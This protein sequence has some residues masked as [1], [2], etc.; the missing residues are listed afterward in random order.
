[1]NAILSSAYWPNL[2]YFYYLIN[3]EQVQIE[4]HEH[5]QKQ[6][7][8]NRTQILSANGVLNLVIPVIQKHKKMPM[9]AVEIDYNENWQMNHWR[10]I[11]SAYKN[12]P[13]FDFFEDELFVFYTQKEKML[14]DYNL[15][16]LELIFKILRKKRNFSLTET[17]ETSFDNMR[18]K[19]FDIH[20]KINF[21][22]D[23]QAYANLVK[24]YYQ[25]FSEKFNFVPN[26]SVL[27]LIFNEGKFASSYL[28][29]E[30]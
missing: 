7:F 28:N 30:M 19:R 27:D 17:F 14:L 10:A 23:L 24:P 29:A 12:S 5:Y 1:M 4:Q 22:Q 21:D 15:K 11:N 18:D 8:R 25:T 2:Q 6:S 26:L 3:S 9:H 13:F 20:P 16:Q